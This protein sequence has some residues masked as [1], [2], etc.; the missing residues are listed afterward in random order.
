MVNRLRKLFLFQ[1]GNVWWKRAWT[2]AKCANFVWI[3]IAGNSLP[4]CRP[5]V[6]GKFLLWWANVNCINSSA[7]TEVAYFLVW[8][9]HCMP[10]SCI[11]H[12]L[13]SYHSSI[14]PT[15][16]FKMDPSEFNSA[17]EFVASLSKAG[18]STNLFTSAKLKF[19]SFRCKSLASKMARG[20]RSQFGI[21]PRYLAVP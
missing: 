3:A 7:R 13:K 18:T 9:K 12:L 5:N 19:F 4:H 17:E 15:I 20:E 8:V 21:S 1:L 16:C 14:H 11:E 2:I 10:R 6:A